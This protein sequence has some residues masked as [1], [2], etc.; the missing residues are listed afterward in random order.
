MPV[1]PSLKRTPNMAANPHPRQSRST[2]V[3]RVPLACQPHQLLQSYGPHYGFSGGASHGSR[4]AVGRAAHS[5]SAARRVQCRA[6][7]DGAEA[8]TPRRGHRRCSRQAQARAR[9]GHGRKALVMQRTAHHLQDGR[10][11]FAPVV[12]RHQGLFVR[13]QLLRDQD[14]HDHA[15]C[16]HGQCHS[17]YY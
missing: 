3:N 16:L 4:E 7:S 5:R 15:P 14:S 9:D 12:H 1:N 11:Q 8:R 6:R 13:L 10:A 17:H 2:A